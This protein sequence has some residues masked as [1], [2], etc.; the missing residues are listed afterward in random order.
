MVVVGGSMSLCGE[1]DIEVSLVQ[2]Q[3]R[4][5]DLFKALVMWADLR[6][7]GLCPGVLGLESLSMI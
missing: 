2:E 6:N 5:R 1:R 4:V 3:E 7:L